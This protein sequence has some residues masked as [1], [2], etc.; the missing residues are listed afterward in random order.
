MKVISN[1]NLKCI[2]ALAALESVTDPEIG[3]NVMG[4]G[5]ICQIDFDE[6]NLKIL[7]AMTLTTAFCPMGESIMAAVKRVVENIFANMEV[8]FELT[9]NPTWNHELISEAGQL[10]LIK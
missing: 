8:Q 1:N 6:V 5:L 10:F 7:I 3:L 4:L 2:I 9:F